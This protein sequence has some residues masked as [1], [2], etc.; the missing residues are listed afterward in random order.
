MASSVTL[1]RVTTDLDEPYERRTQQPLA[2]VDAE[3]ACE[4]I[5]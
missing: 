1:R 3:P 2:R 4:R 5:R